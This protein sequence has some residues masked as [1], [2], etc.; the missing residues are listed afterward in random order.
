MCAHLSYVELVALFPPLYG[1]HPQRPFLLRAVRGIQSVQLGLHIWD[2]HLRPKTSKSPKQRVSRGRHEFE[3][4]LPPQHTPPLTFPNHN[5]SPACQ[6]LQ[7]Q[8]ALR[9]AHALKSIHILHWQKSANVA[10]ATDLR[11]HKSGPRCL[12]TLP[13]LVRKRSKDA[14]CLRLCVPIGPALPCVTG[15]R[16]DPYRLA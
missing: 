14:H 3:Q 1:R 6:P 13:T 16:L 4:P 11:L 15:T 12:L 9:D 10:F 5:A 2:Q 7:R 8:P